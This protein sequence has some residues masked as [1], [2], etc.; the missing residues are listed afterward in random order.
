MRVRWRCGR[1]LWMSDV[2]LL[3]GTAQVFS[4]TALSL[5]TL[6]RPM[7][8]KGQKRGAG[9]ADPRFRCSRGRYVVFQRCPLYLYAPWAAPSPPSLPSLPCDFDRLY[10]TFTSTAH[11]RG[12]GGEIP[13]SLGGLSNPLMGACLSFHTPHS[14][15][16]VCQSRRRPCSSTR[17]PRPQQR[18]PCGSVYLEP[19]LPS[20]STGRVLGRTLAMMAAHACVY[21]PPRLLG[22]G[23]SC[24]LGFHWLST[25]PSLSAGPGR[26]D[27]CVIAVWLPRCGVVQCCCVVATP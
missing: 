2:R 6:S 19:P 25:P 3:V 21:P 12:V 20:V 18:I 27:L 7:A 26:I 23:P 5:A 15:H 9:G 24:H 16:C 10:R 4:S 14:T 1:A 17:P 13:G 11:S 8:G 22:V